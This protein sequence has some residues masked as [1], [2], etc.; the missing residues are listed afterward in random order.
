[1][2]THRLNQGLVEVVATPGL[3]VATPVELPI[4]P[5]SPAAFTQTYSTVASTVPNATYAAPTETANTQVLTA[6][7]IA[8]KTASLTY[9][10]VDGTNATTAADT[11]NQNFKNVGTYIN[12]V[13]SNLA[14]SNTKLAA[15]AVDVI[16]LKKVIGKLVDILQAAG[17]AS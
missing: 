17:L 7:T 3:F 11:A 13:N 4:V 12:V 1:M 6:T 14:S 15:L 5:A 9:I 10:D 8:G 2:A 16:E